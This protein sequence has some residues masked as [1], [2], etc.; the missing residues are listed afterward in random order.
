MKIVDVIVRKIHHR[1]NTVRDSEG[2]VHPGPDHD[3]VQPEVIQEVGHRLG[4]HDF[5]GVLGH[6]GA[7]V[8]KAGRRDHAVA[9][10]GQPHV[11]DNPG[12]QQ[13]D[14]VAGHRIAEAGVEFL[15]HRR[16]AHDVGLPVGGA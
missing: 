6:R 14:G 11:G 10:I 3:A 9:V 2:H 16:P 5:V 1:S 4:L 12:L 13:A 7:E 8:S 15:G